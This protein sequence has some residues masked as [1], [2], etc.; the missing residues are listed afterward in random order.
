MVIIFL[1]VSWMPKNCFDFSLYKT[2]VKKIAFEN[3]E[4]CK[5]NWTYLKLS[6]QLK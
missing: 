3:K 1:K 4:S 2:N 5:I 6:K